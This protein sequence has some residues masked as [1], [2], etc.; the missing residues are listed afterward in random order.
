MSDTREQA[1]AGGDGGVPGVATTGLAESLDVSQRD[2]VH[3]LRKHAVGLMGVLFLTVTGSAPISAMLFN[4]P[5]V[6][7]FGNGVGAPAAFIFATIVLVIFSVGYVAMARKKTTAGGFYSYI[8]HGL[9]RE[10]GIGTGFGSVLAYSVFE[11]SLCG[12]FAYF[13]NLKLAQFGL[14]VGWPW[15]ALAMVVII[16]L[17]TYF[18]VRLSSI[19]LGVGLI[20]EI[21]ML[22]IFDGFMFAHGHLPTAAINPVNAFKGF[23]A[24]GKLAAGAV[25]IGLFFAFWSWVG[26]EMAPNYGEESKNPKRN[27]P[28]ALYISVIGLGIFYIITSWAPFAGYASVHAAEAQAQSNAAQYYLGPANAIAGRWVGSILS[29]LIITGSF[30][31]GMAFHNTTSR[32]FYSLGREGLLPRA[33]G[34]THP[35]WK[36]PHIASI[37]QS[38]IAALIVIGFAVFTGSNDPSSQAYIQLYGLMAVMGVIVILAVQALVSLSILIYFQRHHEDEVHWWRTI[39][40]PALSFISQVFVVFLLFKNISF[41]G[42]GYGYAKFLGPIDLLVV[43]IGIGAAFYLK[44]RNRAK[45]ESAGRLINEGL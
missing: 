30:A 6:V 16:S 38:V 32:Y 34:R 11:A 28:R 10:I 27:V 5:I 29:Y 37:T 12:G 15:L 36:S 21:V 26:F 20:G 39:V 41:L 13:A 23:P 14:N 24:A 45:Y 9:G 35:K 1:P 2:D 44:H 8:S 4:T 22:L 42:S 25:G 7:G 43:L 3:K 33:L 18:D 40:A 31:C 19:I 17:L